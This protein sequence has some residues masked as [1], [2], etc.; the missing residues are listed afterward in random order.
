VRFVGNRSSGKLGFALAERALRR[1][2]R[3]TLIAGPVSLPTPA[4][5]VRHDVRS[6]ADLRAALWDVLGS[7]LSGADA[8]VMAA[9]VADYRP[10]QA[11][12]QKLKRGN[13]PLALE[14]VPNPDLLAEIGHTRRGARPV[15]VGFA[16]GT[17]SDERV[18]E[19]A[20]AKLAEKRVDFV[21]ANRAD[22]AIG[23]DDIRALL[24]GPQSVETIE[25]VDKRA[26]AEK[27]LDRLA[28]ALAGLPPTE[29]T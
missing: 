20:R 18:L 13:A 27:I 28:G 24:V 17:D 1:G 2:A 16:L 9:A 14:L 21:V 26:A 29:P 7:D 22:E 10:A 6:A 23:T 25:R 3:V 8:L 5:A 4:G 12:S 19:S 15:L 11:S